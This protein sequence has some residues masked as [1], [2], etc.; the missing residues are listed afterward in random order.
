MLRDLTMGSFVLG[1]GLA[2]SVACGGA[3]SDE[4]T[5]EPGETKVQ[6]QVVGTV[7]LREGNCMPVTTP[8]HCR[9]R[10]LTARVE[11]YRVIHLA[12]DD[13]S[14]S[15]FVVPPG[16]T[17][18]QTTTSDADGRFSFVLPE[19]RYTILTFYEGSWYPE[20]WGSG[21]EWAGVEVNAAWLEDLDL[22]I[23]RASE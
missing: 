5:D 13:K 2:T 1:L 19:G 17:P 3:T 12:N 14:S 6:A 18:V 20:S 16:M 23:N 21:G 15:R 22:Q 9:V 10:G 11:A 8:E 7:T 4:P